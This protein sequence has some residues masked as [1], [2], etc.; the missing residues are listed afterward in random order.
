LGEVERVGGVVLGEVDGEQV[1]C[2]GLA[3]AKLAEGLARE[4]AAAGDARDDADR[5]GVQGL[6]GRDAEGLVSRE[7][8]LDVG[9]AA[10]VGEGELG[11][12]GGAEALAREAELV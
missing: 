5:S 8:E 1:G 6:E 2:V 12:R 10:E 4:A 3:E 7:A 11:G 9:G